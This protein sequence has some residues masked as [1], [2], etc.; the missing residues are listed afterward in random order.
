MGTMAHDHD[1]TQPITWWDRLH[2]SDPLGLPTRKSRRR[3]W[4][5]LVMCST[6]AFIIA[7]GVDV[8]IHHMPDPFTNPPATEEPN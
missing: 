2:S 8:L 3:Y 4:T 1:D 7:F 6:A 5:M